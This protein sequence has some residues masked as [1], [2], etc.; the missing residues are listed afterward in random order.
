MSNKLDFPQIIE[1]EEG[2]H[3]QALDFKTWYQPIFEL[4]RGDSVESIHHGAVAVVD[5][6]GKLLAWFG[7]A[8]AVTFLRSTAKPL[9]VLAFLENGGQDYY[10]L[11]RREIALMCA[12][13]GGTDQH[14]A[15]A[16][17]I[18]SK[19]GMDEADLLCGVHI[20][21][22]EQTAEAMRDRREQP[23]PNHHNCS[24][25]HSGMVAFA[26]MLAKENRLRRSDLPY[27]DFMHP[28]QIEIRRT[29]AEMCALPVDQVAMG[30]DGCSAPNFAVPLYNA[31]LAFA[32]LCD[33]GAGGVRPPERTVACRTVTAAMMENP[34][35]VA[36]PGRFDTRLMQVAAG[37]MVSKGGAEGYQG[38]G[39]MPG[40]LGPGSP[41]LGI[42]FKVADGDARQ[43]VRPALALE[44]LRQLGALSPQ[45]LAELSEFGP[46]FAVSNW[47]KIIVGRARPLL[48]LQNG[49]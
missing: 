30:I 29:F 21:A 9:Q 4:T 47:R 14:V 39:L 16:R 8:E 43:K 26:R 18:Q 37:R 38:I 1:H 20:P 12:S 25:K 44:I 23:T 48:K 3:L 28:I 17:S 27:I 41:A 15:V 2:S 36:G 7:S 40:L 49:T 35:M 13:H 11:T 22:D 24:G 34:D 5:S 42:A 32:R 31:A 6:L 33:L 46:E 19:V 45:E 10:G